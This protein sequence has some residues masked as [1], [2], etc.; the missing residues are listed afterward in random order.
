MSLVAVAGVIMI[1]IANVNTALKAR[2]YWQHFLGQN[3][4]NNDRLF[5]CLGGQSSTLYLN[6]V[7]FF[8]TSVD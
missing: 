3:I 2:V 8:N 6:V 7:Q 5:T 1:N 4:G